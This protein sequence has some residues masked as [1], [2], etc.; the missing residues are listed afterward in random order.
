MHADYG[1]RFLSTAPM[2]VGTALAVSPQ[3][4]VW[5]YFGLVA[6]SVALGFETLRALLSLLVYVLRDGYG[7]D[8]VQ[9]GILAIVIFGTG[10]QAGP[11]TRLL[12]AS[13]SLVIAA[14]GLGLTRLLAHSI[15]AFPLVDLGFTVVGAFLFILFIYAAVAYSRTS[16]GPGAANCGLGVLLGIAM[17][18]FIMGAFDT[19]EPF[20]RV[21]VGP[22]GPSP[23]CSWLRS[24]ASFLYWCWA[25]CSDRT[26]PENSDPEATQQKS[27]SSVPWIALGPVIFLQ[28]QVFQNLAA[29][30]AVTG[31]TLPQAFLWLVISNVVGLLFAAMVAFRPS[32]AGAWVP[33]LLMG[34]PSHSLPRLSRPRL[35]GRRQQPLLSVKRSC[36]P[37]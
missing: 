36:P 3:P 15:P 27:G 34:A 18:T 6:I 31:W 12:G 5:P 2:A 8:A 33:T 28:L 20:W 1:S 13:T 37:S 19:W 24:P 32:T 25:G 29:F 11:L 9:V 22:H 17:D 21:G 26:L 10:F 23:S 4:G 30:A 35:P 16:Y 14:G 7:W